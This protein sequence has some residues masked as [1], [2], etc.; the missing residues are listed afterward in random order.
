MFD[1]GLMTI[2]TPPKFLTAIQSSLTGKWGPHRKCFVAQD[3]S[4]LAGRLS[5]VCYLAPWLRHI[6]PHLYLS[7]ATALRLNWAH[8]INTSRSFWEGM[9]ALRLAPL[10][11]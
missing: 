4:V 10:S 6:M 2:A 11:A 3:A 5:H 7:L 9:K 1:T 8:L